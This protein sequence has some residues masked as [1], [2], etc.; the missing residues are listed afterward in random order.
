M[1][2]TI[3]SN[4][5]NKIIQI[6]CDGFEDHESKWDSKTKGLTRSGIQKYAYYLFR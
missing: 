4:I 6:M 2:R 5:C 3:T 1:D